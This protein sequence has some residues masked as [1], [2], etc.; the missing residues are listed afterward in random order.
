MSEEKIETEE[1][2]KNRELIEGVAKNIRNL[3]NAVNALLNG[4]LKRQAIE[5]LVTYSSKVPRAQ[6]NAVLVALENLDSK[7]LN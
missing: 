1:Q 3:A 7:F 4:P 5:I 2:K 6:V